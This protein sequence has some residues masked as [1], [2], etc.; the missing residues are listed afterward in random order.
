MYVL[1][2]ISITSN[3]G[4]PREAISLARLSRGGPSTYC[5]LPPRF[6]I[7][8]PISSCTARSQPPPNVAT[9]SVTPSKR[10]SCAAAGTA[11]RR[12]VKA[13]LPNIHRFIVMITPASMATAQQRVDADPLLKQHESAERGHD[14]GRGHRQQRRVELVVQRLEQQHRERLHVGARQEQRDRQVGERHQ[15]GVGCTRIHGG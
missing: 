4:L 10:G 6:S 14:D 1:S 9:R 13:I 8:T 3:G 12:A 7:S 11:A 5:T 15:E 2:S